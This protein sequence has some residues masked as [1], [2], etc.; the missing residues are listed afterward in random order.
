MTAESTHH[1]EIDQSKIALLLVDVINDFEFPDSDE[2]LA[3]ALPLV[4]EIAALR[5]R[6]EQAKIPIIYAN[7]NFGK[8]RSDFRAIVQHC[9]HEGKGRKFTAQLTPGAD[10]YFIL[11]PRHSAFFSTSLEI[12]LR[13]LGVDSVILA[14]LAGNNCILFTAND[15]YLRKLN[16]IVPEDCV[17]SNS[18]EDNMQAL[19]LMK[20]ILKA[21]TRPSSWLTVAKLRE[22]SAACPSVDAINSSS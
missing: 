20:K 4:H 16:V 14:G 3:N 5:S 1:E 12:L 10:H 17:A 13:S 18:Q 7:D 19:G 9:L 2:L 6:A 8:W 22:L 15:A 11:K 21:D